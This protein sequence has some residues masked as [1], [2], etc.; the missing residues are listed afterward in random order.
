MKSESIAKPKPMRQAWQKQAAF[1]AAYVVLGVIIVMLPRLVSAYVESMVVR[2]LILGIFATSLNLLWGY[3]G[4]V[5]LGHAAYFGMGGYTAGILMVHYGITSFWI[6]APLSILM[7][8]F[9][10]AI[11]GILALR[12]AGAYFMLVTIAMGE[13]LYSVALKW[14]TM[15]GGS[16]SLV[17]ISYPDLGLPWFTMNATYYYYFVFI[18]FVICLF[19]MYRIIKSPFGYALQGIR[20]NE[21]RMR[22]LGYNTWWYKYIAFIVAGL[23]AGVAGV[24]FASLNGTIAPSH[25]GIETSTLAMLMLILGSSSTVFGPVLGAALVVS[26]QYFSSIYVPERWPLIL[27]SVFVLSVM[28]L[29]G[30]IGIHLVRLW[31]R[32]YYGSIKG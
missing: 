24:L 23:F 14:R 16:Y 26:I 15:T 4:L 22:A 3:T 27:G 9:T 10:A 28:F 5:S 21:P 18:V 1:Y 12:A 19:L 7:T 30:G 32:V 8:T 2:I 29:R 31:K 13:L 6:N 17:G 25:L 11:F 20:G